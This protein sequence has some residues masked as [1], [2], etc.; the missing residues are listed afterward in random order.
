MIRRSFGTR[1]DREDDDPAIP[2]R[3]CFGLNPESN[4]LEYEVDCID[5]IGKC[6]TAYHLPRRLIRNP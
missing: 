3:D 1:R 2:M 5:Q 4:F 6:L